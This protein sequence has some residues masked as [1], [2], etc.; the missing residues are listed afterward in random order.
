[1]ATFPYSTSSELTEYYTE[2][3]NKGYDVG[4][5]KGYRQGSNDAKTISYG[6]AKVEATQKKFSKFLEA[7]ELEEGLKETLIEACKVILEDAAPPASVGVGQGMGTVSAGVTLQPGMFHMPTIHK[8][9][10]KVQQM[11]KEYNEFIKST[12]K[13]RLGKFKSFMENMGLK[14][15]LSV[16][17]HEAFE[18]ILE[19]SEMSWSATEP[20]GMDFFSDKFGVTSPMFNL[21]VPASGGTDFDVNRNPASAG[22]GVTPQT[23]VETKPKDAYRF[24]KAVLNSGKDIKKLMGVANSKI[25]QVDK[26]NASPS[27]FFHYVNFS[28]TQQF[29]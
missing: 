14:P 29:F 27:P 1:M 21:T 9:H 23:S 25:P 17:L 26:M 13:K 20:Y 2:G 22:F 18:T 4:F 15:T 8:A 28:N 5:K 11:Q 7:M 10:P 6:K 16:S 24:P 12:N 3:Y 19:Y